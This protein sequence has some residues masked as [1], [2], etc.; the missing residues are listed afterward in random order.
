[1][2]GSVIFV[3]LNREEDLVSSVYLYPNEEEGNIKNVY[4]SKHLLLVSFSFVFCRS[5][6]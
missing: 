5:N 1:M 4:D 3:V 2:N 6:F